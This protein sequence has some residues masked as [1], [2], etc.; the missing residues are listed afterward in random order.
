MMEN[1]GKEYCNKTY[2][3]IS[4]ASIG[5]VYKVCLGRLAS[6]VKKIS[7]GVTK[8]KDE[9]DDEDSSEEESSEDEEGADTTLGDLDSTNNFAEE[10]DS[11]D[12]SDDDDV[13][14]LRI[15]KCCSLRIFSGL[16]WE[17]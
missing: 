7:Y 4:R 2:Q 11:N 17:F 6:L 9:R 14:S 10:E 15:F 1:R 16:A 5:V 8:D 12:E 13:H 3:T